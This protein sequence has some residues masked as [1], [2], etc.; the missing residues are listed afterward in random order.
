MEAS[1]PSLVTKT[2]PPEAK[3]TATGIYSSSQ[4]LGIFIGGVAGGWVHQTAGDGSVFACS[5]ALALLWLLVAAT[6]KQPS[7]LTTRLIRIR[8][9][10]ALDAEKLAAMLRQVPGVA[11]A[12]VIAEEELAYLKVDARTFDSDMVQSLV[13]AV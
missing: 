1:L 3:G 2:A 12:V 11:E 7:Y 4:F 13:G 6:M 10:G 5:A 9:G 8:D